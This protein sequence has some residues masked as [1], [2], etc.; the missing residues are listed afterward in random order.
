MKIFGAVSIREERGM[1]QR[2]QGNMSGVDHIFQMTEQTE[3]FTER[4]RSLSP[5][6]DP[7]LRLASEHPYLFLPQPQVQFVAADR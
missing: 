7:C 3:L 6:I 1:C 4:S 2:M 5:S